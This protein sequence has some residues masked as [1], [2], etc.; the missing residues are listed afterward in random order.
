MTY[1]EGLGGFS[2]SLADG[3]R[4][5]SSV[6]WLGDLNDDGVEDLAVGAPGSDGAGVDRGA[7]WLLF[8]QSDDTVAS[9]VRINDATP[10]L[11]G[12]LLDH[13]AF[14]T[15]VAGVGDVDR[16]GWPDLAVGAPATNDAANAGVVHVLF[17]RADGSVKGDA[18]IGDGLGGFPLSIGTDDLFGLS[19][20]SLGDVDGNAIGDLAVGRSKRGTI[21]TIRLL[22]GG[23]VKGVWE[24]GDGLG[25]FASANGPYLGAGMAS[26]GDIDGDGVIDLGLGEADDVNYPL[27]VANSTWVARLASNG[28][29]VGEVET[30]SGDSIYENG[31]ASTTVLGADVAGLGDIDGDGIPDAVFGSPGLCEPGATSGTG[32]ERGAAWVTLLQADG[33][34]RKTVRISDSKGGLPFILED[35][36]RF[37]NG[38]ASRGDVD[39]DGVPDLAVG[40]PGTD[41]LGVDRGAL[42]LLYLVGNDFPAA[43]V[44]RNGIGINDPCLTNLTVPSIGLVWFA[45]LDSSFVPGAPFS[46]VL[47]YDSKLDPGF[48]FSGEE[49]LVN[50]VT[51]TLIRGFV[52]FPGSPGGFGFGIPDDASILGAQVFAQ[53]FVG[54]PGGGFELCNAIDLTIGN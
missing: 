52:G 53:A 32:D 24:V 50:S 19:L 25:G 13:A 45:Q 39:G 17:L 49:L 51:G 46:G 28:T 41:G 44:E 11:S 31:R 4:F 35:G 36:A 5:G 15:D 40:A 18:L 48:V 26:L 12:P 33:S 7:V 54:R 6:A 14:G 10:G 1:G 2:G 37:G 8:L 9:A 21:Y 43:A 22:Q 47:V 29:V 30:Q 23:G 20:A 38:L 27:N 42:H 16:D 3:D 34:I